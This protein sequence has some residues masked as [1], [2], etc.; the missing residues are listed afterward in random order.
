MSSFVPA[1]VFTDKSPFMLFSGSRP[2]KM[3]FFMTCSV[4]FC[5]KRIIN[6]DR[7]TKHY[8]SPVPF[9]HLSEERQCGVTFLVLGNNMMCAETRGAPHLAKWNTQMEHAD[10]LEI[11]WNFKPKILAKQITP[12][13][14]I[15]RPSDLPI[16]R[17][18]CL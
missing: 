14:L 9:R 10:Q 11:F 16:E 5:E 12:K 18:S 2:D 1:R 6:C 17:Y 4:N 7:F 8:G 3:W 15:H 13:D